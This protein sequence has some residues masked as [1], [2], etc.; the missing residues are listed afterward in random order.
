MLIQPKFSSDREKSANS[1]VMQHEGIAADM[2]S[3]ETGAPHVGAHSLDDEAP[4]QLSDG[5]DDDDDGAAQ[6]AAM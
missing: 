4:F 2:R 6:R 1:S 3:F 5:A